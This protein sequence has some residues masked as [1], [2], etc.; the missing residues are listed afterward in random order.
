[1]RTRTIDAAVGRWKGILLALGL[2]ERLLSGKHGP[3]PMCGGKDRFRFADQEGSGNFFCNKCGSGSGIELAMKITGKDFK[4]VANEIDK[5]VGRIQ[6]QEPRRSKGDAEKIKRILA[7]CRPPKT[8]G[9]VRKY[10]QSRGVPF[11]PAL[12]EHPALAYYED[13]KEKGKHPAMVAILASN[14]GATLGLHVTYLGDGKKADVA[15]QK[16]IFKAGNSLGQSVVMLTKKYAHM[17]VAEGIE[18]ALAV[19][20]KMKVP[21][22]AATSAGMLEKFNPPE[23]VT[24]ISIF[25]DNDESFTGQKSAYTLANRICQQVKCNVILPPKVGDFADE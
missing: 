18:T 19:M 16:K 25:G 24:E 6:Q 8:G 14:E 11:S 13:G 7:G 5:L 4:A 21:C 2:E 1:M 22:W 17:G 23:G 12:R 15:Q 20:K 10:L 9:P 3:C